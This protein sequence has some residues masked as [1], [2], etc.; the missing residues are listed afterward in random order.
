MAMNDGSTD[1]QLSD[2]GNP[3][4]GNPADAP[5]RRQTWGALE[6][7]EQVAIVQD[8]IA[9][10]CRPNVIRRR[11]ADRWGLATRTSEYRMSAARQQMIRDINT[12]DRAE[13]VGELIEKLDTII[14]QAI[15]RNMGA[16]AIGAMRL[17][18]DLLQLIQRGK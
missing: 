10:G 6:I 18:A 16:N 11:C 12:M 7:A 8:W 3:S 13:K 15:D 17:Q 14:E 4:P 5:K 2:Y 1:A 9:E